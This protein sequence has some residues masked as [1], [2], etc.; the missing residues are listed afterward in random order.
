MLKCFQ[1]CCPG[2]E[3]EAQVPR[4]LQISQWCCCFVDRRGMEDSGQ[5]AIGRRHR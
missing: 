4:M 5:R 1:R 2:D 3:Y